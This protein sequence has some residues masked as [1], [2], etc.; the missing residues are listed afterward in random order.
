MDDNMSVRARR[1]KQAKYKVKQARN[2]ADTALENVNGNPQ[3]I[4]AIEALHEQLDA[5]EE[6]LNV[7]G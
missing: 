2:R 5:L 6:F 3:M 7:E 1:R 4:E